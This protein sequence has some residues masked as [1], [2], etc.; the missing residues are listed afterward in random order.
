MST[1]VHER[2]VLLAGG[3]NIFCIVFILHL[4]SVI[5][6]LCSVVS[7]IMALSPEAIIAMIALFVA[8]APGLRFHH[9]LLPEYGST[10][11]E[12]N[13]NSRTPLYDA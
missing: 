4:D 6:Y 9:H 7:L 13:S 12:P 2:E 11:T 3:A 8:C 5:K 1:R 10:R